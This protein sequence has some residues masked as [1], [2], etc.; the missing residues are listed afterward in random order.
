MQPESD[1]ST[2]SDFWRSLNYFNL[3]RLVL[4]CFIVFIA[5]V[6]DAERLFGAG[7][8]RLFMMTG[9]LYAVVV[10]L[11]FIPLR[12]RWLPFSWQLA[13]VVCSDIVALSVLAHAGGGIQS[14]VGLLLMVSMAV[15]GIISRGKIT[16]FFAALASIAALLEHTFAV[17]YDDA[18]VAQY[19][20]VGLL[21]LSYFAVAGLAH[22][23]A[24]YALENQ[25]LAQRRGRDLIG[26]AEANRLVMR[27]M[28]DGVLV[29][30]EHDSIVQMNPSA[31]RLLHTGEVSGHSLS[32][33][34]P[35]L[36]EQYQQW[37][38]STMSART[39]LQLDDGLQARLRF[40]GVERDAAQGAVIFLEDMQHVQAEAQQIKLAALGRLTANLAHEVRNPLSAISYATELLQEE[41]GDARQAR[42][43]QL[44]RDNTQRINRIIQD[45]MQ[46]N[47]RDRAQPETFELSMFLPV[48]AEEFNQAER[49]E[50][51]VLVLQAEHNRMIAFDRGHFR[52]VLWNLCRNGLHFGRH[53]SG[54]L[55]LVTGIERG[56]VVLEVQD[57]GPGIS[58]EHQSR[59]FE[60]FFTTDDQGTGLGL[61]IA[62][63]LCEANGAWLEY[64]GPAGERKSGACFR[65][66]FGERRFGKRP[67]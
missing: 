49:V 64:H 60:P 12:M 16:L 51:G 66:T 65:I 38:N 58:V 9:G 42:L 3:Y 15:A 36:Y 59:L 33:S 20:Q 8:G 48:F 45:V 13:G 29:V 2:P 22:K 24:Q 63:E 30:D 1:N 41:P 4:V 54:S 39:T 43:L 37:K 5:M 44:I 67:V 10:M 56:R 40:V 57:D 62:R 11:S 61:Y 21:C 32:V 26:M 53:V 47:K 14:S 27:D 50:S 25:N 35:L 31:S 17:L 19:I 28:Q 6:F 52:Q 34:F 23:L 46:L 55:V 7:K 18:S